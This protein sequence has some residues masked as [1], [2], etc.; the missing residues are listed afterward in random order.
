M[1]NDMGSGILI[2]GSNV[3]GGTAN[4]NINGQT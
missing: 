4:V 2:P 3:I 1:V